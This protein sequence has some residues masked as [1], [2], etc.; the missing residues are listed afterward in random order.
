MQYKSVHEA[1]EG[2]R[3]RRKDSS[4]LGQITAPS[5]KPSLSQFRQLTN[6]SSFAVSQLRFPRKKKKKKNQIYRA[7][8]VSFSIDEVMRIFFPHFQDQ[9]E[10][11]EKKAV[12]FGGGGGGEMLLREA[13]PLDPRS[14]VVRSRGREVCTV[15]SQL[16][17]PRPPLSGRS[18]RRRRRRSRRGRLGACFLPS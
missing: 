4:F 18:D 5:Q 13:T 14:R 2:R 8:V 1:G 15:S 17:A 12:I 10:P 3:E 6:T 9:Q 11:V 7:S 16:W